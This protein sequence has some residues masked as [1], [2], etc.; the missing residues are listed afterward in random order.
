[1]HP[2]INDIIAIVLSLG[3]HIQHIE[4]S[5]CMFLCMCAWHVC[6][7]NKHTHSLLLFCNS[8]MYTVA[9]LTKLRY[10]VK[11]AN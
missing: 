9:L 8:L 4:I 11:D 5:T 3:T 1:M 10:F 6:L 7:Y 2:K